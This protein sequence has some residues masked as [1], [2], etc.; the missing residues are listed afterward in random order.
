[1]TG[2]AAGP[3]YVLLA[4]G[5]EERRLPCTDPGEA[6]RRYPFLP[7]G[8][9]VL[10]TPAGERVREVSEPIPWPVEATSEE[11][12]QVASPPPPPLPPAPPLPPPPPSRER[13]LTRGQLLHRERMAR[14]AR[15]EG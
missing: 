8:P 4:A 11:S 12:S 6:R 9:L 14:K 3:W 10:I 2:P 7:A 15:G 5:G 13:K 1:M